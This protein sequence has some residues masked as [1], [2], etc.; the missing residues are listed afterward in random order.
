MIMST[1]ASIG[2]VGLL[3][4]LMQARSAITETTLTA[5]WMWGLVACLTW[6]VAQVATA[7]PSTPNV[8]LDLL[9]YAAAVLAV[10]PFIAVLGARNPG[11]KAWTGFV[12]LPLV[13]VL[14]WP[15]IAML[16]GN[17]G[18]GIEITGP[19]QLGFY[20]AIVMG[21]G[22]YIGTRFTY[23]AI[24][25]MAGVF[26]LLGSS[27][28]SSRAIASMCVVVP[29]LSHGIPQPRSQLTFPASRDEASDFVT[30]YDVIWA[31]FRDFYGLV[32]AKRVI[33]RLNQLFA[34][35]KLPIQIH[36]D[37]LTW[38]SQPISEQ[39]FDHVL[40]KV[41]KSVFWILGRFV[42][43]RWVEARLENVGQDI[44]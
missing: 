21:A 28:S 32:W 36:M 9:W 7:I 34:R 19:I 38:E 11:A 31:D 5:A 22:S 13:L 26:V 41:D 20:V 30:R 18:G 37:G 40:E 6:L 17:Q 2:L 27:A 33:D 4:R 35:D 15:A 25:V 43:E 44:E 1:I 39:E 3:W 8:T 10:C 16:F 23:P 29:I 12:M 42:T 14:S 24:G